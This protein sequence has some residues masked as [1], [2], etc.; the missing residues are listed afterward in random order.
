[1]FRGMLI[2]TGLKIERQGKVIELQKNLDSGATGVVYQ[3]I[4]YPASYQSQSEQCVVKLS[5]R[6]EASE[7]DSI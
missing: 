4:I 1:M 2:Q 5:E 3:A 6:L 7:K